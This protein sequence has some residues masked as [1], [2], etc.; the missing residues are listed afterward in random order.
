VTFPGIKRAL[1]TFVI[2]PGI[3]DWV[4][5][6]MSASSLYSDSAT[7][8]TGASVNKQQTGEARHGR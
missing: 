3:A 4:M 6:E 7:G 5:H 2:A 8:A 1:S